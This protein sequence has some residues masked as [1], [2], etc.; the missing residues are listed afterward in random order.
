MSKDISLQMVENGLDFIVKSIETVEK[1]DEDLKYSI[2]NLH[3]GLQLL[4]KEILFREHWSLIFQKIET[5]KKEKLESG[6]FVSV[7]HDTLIQRLQDICGIK[8]EKQL[9]DDINWLRKERNKIEHYHLA[10][11]LDVLKSNIVR[12]FAYLVPFIKSEMIDSGY[13]ASDNE[14][15]S[16][17]IE[18]LNEFDDYVNSRLELIEDKVSKAQT[19]LQCPAC[20]HETVEFIDETDAFCHFCDEHIDS[21]TSRYIDNFVDTYSHIKDGGESPL[22][23]CPECDQETFIYLD[24]HQYICLTCGINLTQDDI[25]TCDGPRCN[26]RLVYRKNEDSANFCSICMDYFEHA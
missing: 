15:L 11:K 26:E 25:T 21:F 13:I 1:S 7:N 8:F 23:E 10:I 9:L 24:E 6:D 17:I 18:Y 19:V 4:L 2:I 22:M 20:Y 12:L 16:E 5:A 3:A 14:M